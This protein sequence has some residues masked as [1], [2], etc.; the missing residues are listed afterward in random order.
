MS[1][2]KALAQCEIQTASCLHKFFV[3]LDKFFWRYLKKFPDYRQHPSSLIPSFLWKEIKMGV[4]MEEFHLLESLIAFWCIYTNQK[5]DLN[6]LKHN[7][8][9]GNCLFTMNQPD[10]LHFSPPP[11]PAP[12]SRDS[13]YPSSHLPFLPTSLSLANTFPQVAAPATV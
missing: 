13:T 2:L 12:L 7:L 6:L 8:H 3:I 11:P 9:N 4:K 10:R 5:E 1:F